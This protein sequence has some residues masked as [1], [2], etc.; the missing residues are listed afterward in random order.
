L[1]TKPSFTFLSQTTSSKPAT[2][3]PLTSPRP[4][5]NSTSPTSP[6]EKPVLAAHKPGTLLFARG[7]GERLRSQE[8]FPEYFKNRAANFDVG[9]DV[10]AC[11]WGDAAG[12]EFASKS[13]PDPPEQT[14]LDR[15]QALEWSYYDADPLFGLR[16][17]SL[18]DQGKPDQSYKVR[19]LGSWRWK[20]SALANAALGR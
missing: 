16:L 9:W 7:T 13:L 19:P 3:C 11:V 1:G 18:P 12:C 10:K 2:I 14:E 5:G 20:R 17:L 8:P 15:Q 4:S 6:T